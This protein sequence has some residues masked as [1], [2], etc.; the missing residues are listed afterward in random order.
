MTV[1][2]KGTRG[3]KTLNLFN[4]YRTNLPQTKIL[5]RLGKY[6]FKTVLLLTMHKVHNYRQNHKLFTYVYNLSC[7]NLL[8]Y[9]FY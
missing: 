4:F 8:D 7:H 5:S 2:G 6:N 9:F 3:R 1:S